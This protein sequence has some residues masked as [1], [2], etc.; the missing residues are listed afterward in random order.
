MKDKDQSWEDLMLVSETP[1]KR[2]ADNT[3]QVVSFD[4]GPDRATNAI[5]AYVHTYQDNVA[6]LSKEMGWDKQK[7]FLQNARIAELETQ[8]DKRIAQ[9]E[10]QLGAQAREK[11]MLAMQIADQAKTHEIFSN[12]ERSFSP[13]EASVLR[14]GNDI[15]IRLVGLN[16]PSAAA[17]I[18]QK[19]F[20]LLTKVR[21]AINAFPGSAVSI[22]GHTDSYGS[23]EQNLKLSKERAEAVKQYLQANSN[24]KASQIEAIGY[25]E[26]KPIAINDTATGRASNRRV[27]VVI[28]PWENGTR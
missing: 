26:S 15:I 17:T 2:I 19:S 13:E 18:E 24:I 10:K 28:R 14:D 22:L 20:G 16:F 3:N 25:G 27:D 11:S 8:L 5:I 21:D 7:L 4:T 9:L 6:E 1:L 12:M 23:D